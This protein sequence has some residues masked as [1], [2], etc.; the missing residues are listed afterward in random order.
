MKHLYQHG[1]W[2]NLSSDTATVL[3]IKSGILMTQELAEELLV[4]V[5]AAIF[6][7]RQ[8]HANHNSNS[9]W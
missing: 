7:A 3:P 8:N 9:V 4:R 1:V 6:D 2:A 5:D